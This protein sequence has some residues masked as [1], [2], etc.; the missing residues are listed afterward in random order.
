MSINQ[1]GYKLINTTDNTVI[2]QWGG[3]WGQCPGIPNPII[4]PNGDQ[5]CGGEIDVEYS[6]YKL[7]VWEM[8]SP[9]SSTPPTPE[10]KLASTG[11]SVDELKQLLG[12]S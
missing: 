11:L 10:E 1:V 6:G 9:S 7:V 3:I 5:I 8:E 4:L 12:L 2:E